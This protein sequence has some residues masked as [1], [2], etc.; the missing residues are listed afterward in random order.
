MNAPARPAILTLPRTEVPISTDPYGGLVKVYGSPGFGKTVLL[1]YL[2]RQVRDNESR[3]SVLSARQDVED[4][5]SDV[6]DPDRIAGSK[7]PE[8]IDR[9][10]RG[11][12]PGEYLLIDLADYY[13]VDNPTLLEKVIAL[14]EEGANLILSNNTPAQDA[15]MMPRPQSVFFLGQVSRHTLVQGAPWLSRLKAGVETSLGQALVTEAGAMSLTGVKVPFIPH[16]HHTNATHAG[17]RD[18]F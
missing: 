18:L 5:Y 16:P 4:E 2:A 11:V 15:S 10:L 14:R 13:F 3:A 8:E 9:V 17:A 12:E 1:R 7:H 6:V